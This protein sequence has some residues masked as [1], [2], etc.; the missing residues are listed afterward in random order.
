MIDFIFLCSVF[1]RNLTIFIHINFELLVCLKVFAFLFFKC[2]V[3]SPY[4]CSPTANSEI[5]D[6]KFD[7]SDNI[8]FIGS[9][10]VTN[11]NF[12]VGKINSNFTSSWQIVYAG[13][14]M[15][16]FEMKD[17]SI[18]FM[19][20]NSNAQFLVK[21]SSTDGSITKSIYNSYTTST[22]SSS[23]WK[24]VK[25]GSDSSSDTLY[26]SGNG[27]ILQSNTSL[28]YLSKYTISGINSVDQLIKAKDSYYYIS[29]WVSS[30]YASLMF[31]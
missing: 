20:I 5:H 27:Y 22:W 17:S 24:I 21:A 9:E 4:P 29:S 14:K 16:S 2:S 3:N 7:S 10:G 8:Y 28:S 18:Y 25:I 23:G 19:V 11:Q 15:Y 6:L 31:E 30:S 12:V 26:A 13:N 1:I